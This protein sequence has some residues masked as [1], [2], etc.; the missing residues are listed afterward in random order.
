MGKR[1]T[2]MT[3]LVL[4]AWLAHALAAAPSVQK[5][6]GEKPSAQTQKTQ[7]AIDPIC[8]MSVHPDKAAGKSEHKGTT[9]YFCSD[10][11]KRKFDTDPEA[12]LKKAL[13]KK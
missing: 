6:T 8:G 11:C 9:Y 4:G 12:A 7:Q 13:P 10:Y 1:I 2:A 3:T 5:P